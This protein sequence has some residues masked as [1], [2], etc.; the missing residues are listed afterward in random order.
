MTKELRD[1][2]E[3]MSY[4]K[5][6]LDVFTEMELQE[7]AAIYIYTDSL[8]CALNAFLRGSAPPSPTECC[9][10][11]LYADYISSGLT[12]CATKYTGMAHR[13]T[14]LFKHEIDGYK[15]AFKEGTGIR[16]SGF[17][18]ATNDWVTACDF[19][20]KAG[21]QPGKIPALLS[22]QSKSGVDI[23]ELSVFSEEREILFNTGLQIKLAQVKVEKGVYYII[24]EEV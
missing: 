22:I 14:A 2:M 24:S 1:R 17:V 11:Q 5:K 21:F 4:N 23:T 7:K 9:N 10:L 18:S 16:F 19:A 8:Y 20:I 6:Y 13:G 12:K 15:I 3:F